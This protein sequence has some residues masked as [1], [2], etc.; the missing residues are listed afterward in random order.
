MLHH[1]AG[2]LDV[3]GSFFFDDL[4]EGMKHPPL[5]RTT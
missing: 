1:L 3:P 5:L 2:I 4:P